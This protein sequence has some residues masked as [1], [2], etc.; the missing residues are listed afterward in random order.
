MDELTQ[1]YINCVVKL[2]DNEEK[3]YIIQE[4]AL[5]HKY[6]LQEKLEEFT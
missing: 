1:S 3:E 6:R 5:D 4:L 2:P